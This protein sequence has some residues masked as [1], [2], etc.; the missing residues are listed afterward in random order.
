M[1]DPLVILLRNNV[2][3]TRLRQRG[4]RYQMAEK[5]AMGP[6]RMLA[7]AFSEDVVV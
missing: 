1:F 5:G 4:T 2:R 7:N 6:V 3:C